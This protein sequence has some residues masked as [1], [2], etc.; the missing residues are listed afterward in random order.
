M[1]GYE[2][3]AEAPSAIAL[4]G[5]IGDTVVI[6][7]DD[8]DTGLTK[9]RLITSDRKGLMAGAYTRRLFSSTRALCMG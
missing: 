4:T 1:S 8:A 9:V 5:I 2:T 7:E 6:I 3:E